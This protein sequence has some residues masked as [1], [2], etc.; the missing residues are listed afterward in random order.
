MSPHE[1]CEDEAFPSHKHFDK[2]LYGVWRYVK[3]FA[4]PVVCQ[5]RAGQSP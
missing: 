4:K 1:A 5:L 2:A 3:D